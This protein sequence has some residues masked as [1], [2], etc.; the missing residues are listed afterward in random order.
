MNAR[1]RN[2]PLISEQS[3]KWSYEVGN[4]YN[5]TCDDEQWKYG[6]IRIW[7]DLVMSTA[8][9]WMSLWWWMMK[10]KFRNEPVMMNAETIGMTLWWWMLTSNEPAMMN[11]ESRK[12]PVM[13]NA[14]SRNDACVD[15][16]WVYDWSCDDEC[17]MGEW[18]WLWGIVF[19]W[20]CDESL[21]RSCDSEL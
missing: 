4:D 15:E 10:A 17:R 2:D 6:N 12:V 7:N 5:W 13:T 20:A 9:I 1:I 11:A 18:G 16:C 19:Q 14:K 21:G 3:L 8:T